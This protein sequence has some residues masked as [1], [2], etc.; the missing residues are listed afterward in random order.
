MHNNMTMHLAGTT[1]SKKYYIPYPDPVKLV[2]AKVGV[3]TAQADTAS[4][5]TIRPKGATNPV[6]TADLQNV[7]AGAVVEFAISDSA[8][9]AEIKTLYDDDTPMELDINLSSA[10]DL[11]LNVEFDPF[12][13]SENPW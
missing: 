10:S 5:I 8:T 9:A 12:A 13:I 7:A 6:L 3:T 1:S 11:M 4:T 2:S